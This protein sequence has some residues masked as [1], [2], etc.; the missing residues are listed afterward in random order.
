M[1]LKI[2][3]PDVWDFLAGDGRPV[4]VYGMGNAAERII[5]LL[6]ERGVE[7]SGIFASDEFVRGHSFMGKRVLRYS[8]I[9]EKYDDFNVVLAF[10]SNRIAVIE[11]IRKINS[12]HRVFAPDIPVAGGGL[13]TGKYFEEHRSEF[14]RVYSLLADDESRRVYESVIKF[15][16]SGKADYLFDCCEYDKNRIYADILKLN[17]NEIIV[18]AGAYDGD[19]IREFTGFTNGR[20]KY[21]YALEPD[22]KNFKKLEKNTAEMKNI[23][24]INAAAWDKREKLIF[25]AKAGRNSMLSASGYTVDG[26]DIDSVAENG[27]TL[28]K[29]DIEGAE[30]KALCGCAKTI[31]KYSPKLYICAY[32]RNEDLFALPLKIRELGGYKIYFRHSA[33]IPAWESN[34]YCVPDTGEE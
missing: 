32:H 14:E 27:A 26:I 4:V 16:I 28:I 2:N 30:M 15:K 34:F 33:Y 12:Q 6:S 21:I 5:G 31:R 19:T 22:P 18:D 8:E 29:M 25:S 7:I 11:N 23:S 1:N 20:F 10:A 9:C 17:E 3:E 24:L 13:F